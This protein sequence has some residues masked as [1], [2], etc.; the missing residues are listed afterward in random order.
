M[1][2]KHKR[3]VT[4]TLADDN[5]NY[6]ERFSCSWDEGGQWARFSSD[7]FQFTITLEG[8]GKLKELVD[9]FVAYHE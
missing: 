7:E 6:S 9:A 4:H 1:T 3:V 5:G 8:V 2:V